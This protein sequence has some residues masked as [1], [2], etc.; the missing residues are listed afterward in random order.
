MWSRLVHGWPHLDFA[1]H[2]LKV[3]TTLQ[4]ILRRTPDLREL[5]LSPVDKV[6]WKSGA[7]Q[8]D[9]HGCLNKVLAGAKQGSRSLEIL[10]LRGFNLS[11]P[12][13]VT[14]LYLIGA[15]RSFPL[16]SELNIEVC[17]RNIFLDVQ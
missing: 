17:I 1:E 15:A 3:E 6:D 4:A 9:I 5:A 8:R 13:S 11:V 16:L 12:D 10:S 14:M 2:L 7:G